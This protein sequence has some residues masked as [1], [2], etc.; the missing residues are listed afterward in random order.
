[1]FFFSFWFSE[2]N[3]LDNQSIVARMA[4]PK[5][6]YEVSEASGFALIMSVDAV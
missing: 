2:A 3:K 1:V 6:F 5:L 4:V